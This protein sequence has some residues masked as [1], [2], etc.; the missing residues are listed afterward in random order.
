MREKKT[1]AESDENGMRLTL[2]YRE[3]ICIIYLSLCSRTLFICLAVGCVCLCWDFFYFTI[4]LLWKIH[5]KV[6][7]VI[8][9]VF[10]FGIELE[11]IK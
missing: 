1:Q 6:N 8:V 5:D 11:V 4:S 7:L 10:V 9:C 2:I 3:R